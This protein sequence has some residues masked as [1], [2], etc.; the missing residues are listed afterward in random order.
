MYS[1]T[2]FSIDFQEAAM[3]SGIRKAV[4]STNRTEIPSTPIR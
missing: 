1:G 4:S 2:R 3:Q